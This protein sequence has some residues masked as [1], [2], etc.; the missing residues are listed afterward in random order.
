MTAPVFLTALGAHIPDGK[1]TVQEAIAAGQYDTE[2]A[3]T[4]EFTSLCIEESLSA[5]D[6][7]LRAARSVVGKTERD[8]IN[9]LY[10]TC[11]HRH[12]HKLLW[13]AASYLQHALDLGTRARVLTINHG[14]NGAFVAASLAIDMIRAGVKGDHL[15]LGAD[16][17]SGS[18]FDRFNSD[19]GTLY[20]D[21]AFA[22]RF[23]RD[24][25]PY[26]VRAMVLE[27]EPALESLYRD[28][29]SADESDADHDIKSAKRTWLKTHGRKGFNQLFVPALQR[30]RAALLDEVD[31][32]SQPAD[33]I[34]Y[35]N[36]GAGLSAKLY[37]GELAD[38]A[39]RHM[40]DFGRS[41][42]HTGTSDQFLG[43]WQLHQRQTLTKGQ[44]VLLIGAGN[45]LSLA[46]LLLEKT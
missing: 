28:S 29:Q 12:G 11:I 42:G 22:A 27:S 1:F 14:C 23:S 39:Q 16:R 5:P 46:G 3:I 17:F 13:P 30:L 35:P 38:L 9:T 32:V 33:Y 37:A 34:I 10:L 45:G 20:G 24:Q 2:R 41:I 18:A 7:A 44:R 4:D 31:L 15:V 21:G 19:L 43:L 40:W 8:V 6:M 26:Q 36:V 25:G